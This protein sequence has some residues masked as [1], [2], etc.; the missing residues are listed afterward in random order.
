M[1]ICLQITSVSIFVAKAPKTSSI[2]IY[3]VSRLKKK[4]ITFK[5]WYWK[6]AMGII[7]ACSN[8]FPWTISYPGSLFFVSSLHPQPPHTQRVLIIWGCS[9]RKRFV[10]EVGGRRFSWRGVLTG[11]QTLIRGGRVTGKLLRIKLWC[12]IFV[13]NFLRSYSMNAKYSLYFLSWNLRSPAGNESQKLQ[14]I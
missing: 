7:T 14:F 1:R 10:Q 2:F 3:I 6:T 11:E 12:I 5:F 13:L 4:Q 9:A 8:M